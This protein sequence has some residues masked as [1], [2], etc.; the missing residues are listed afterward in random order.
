MTT[1]AKLLPALRHRLRS[2]LSKPLA[3]TPSLKCAIRLDIRN[4]GGPALRDRP[5]KF[6]GNINSQTVGSTR[7]LQQ[8]RP[9]RLA[10]FVAG[11]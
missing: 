10:R 5:Y 3:S 6:N 7:R 2:K 9:A 4:E 11:R 1:K 8:A